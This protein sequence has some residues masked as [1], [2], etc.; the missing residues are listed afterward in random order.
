MRLMA[1]RYGADIVY[2]EEIVDRAILGSTRVV[3]GAP[4]LPLLL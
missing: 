1:R 3:D 2:A 4:L